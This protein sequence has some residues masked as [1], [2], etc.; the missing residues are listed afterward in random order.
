MTI[1]MPPT[2][3]FP[4]YRDRSPNEPSIHC[5]AER[6]L[7]LYNQDSGKTAKRI[8]QAVRTWFTRTAKKQGWTDVQWFR[9]ASTKNGAGCVLSIFAFGLD[10]DANEEDDE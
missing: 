6:V 5:T 4:D 10:A 7:A 1:R 3:K 2:Y 8:S 9:D